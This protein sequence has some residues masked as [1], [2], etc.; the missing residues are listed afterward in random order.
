M[1]VVLQALAAPAA[2]PWN[3]TVLLPWLDPKFD[4][5]MVT[6]VPAR[7]EVGARLAMLGT[8]A[9]TVSVSAALVTL[10][11]AAV[12][13]VVPALTPVARPL[14]SI[15]AT[16]VALL[17]HVNVTPLMLFPLP[18]F[19]V[20]VN[21]CVAPTRI[22]G[23]AGVTVMLA[24]AGPV[25]VSVSAALVTPLAEAVICVVPALTPVATPLLLTVATPALLL[26]HVNVTPLTVVPLL[27]FAVAVNCWVAPTAIEGDAGD[28]VM[29]ATVWLLD[30]PPHWV[31][32]QHNER[33]A[34]QRTNFRTTAVGKELKCMETPISRE[35]KFSFEQRRAYGPR[36]TRKHHHRMAR[37]TRTAS[38]S[39]EHPV[40]SPSAQRSMFRRRILYETAIHTEAPQNQRLVQT[41][42]NR[43]INPDRA[44]RLRSPGCIAL[45][46]GAKLNPPPFSH[47][48]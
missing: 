40:C 37:G 46:N 39:S 43:F 14:L 1:L 17:V 22:D 42:T 8:G 10:L 45:C 3:V 16:P 18:S 48:L 5:V 27:F 21:C 6:G 28:T 4:P 13:C 9:D 25:T 32:V 11:A 26:V 30:P 47:S 24:T 2:V 19:A 15:V 33:T 41:L 34:R 36:R 31:S 35:G 29:L 12:I 38:L 7:P 44:M 20:A 23:D